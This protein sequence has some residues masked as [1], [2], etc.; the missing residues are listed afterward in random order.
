[1][2][3]SIRSGLFALGLLSS[4]VIVG[5]A[6]GEEPKTDLENT[7]LSKIPYLNR[8]FKNVS[9]DAQACEECES[10]VAPAPKFKLF[11]AEGAGVTA[12]QAGIRISAVEFPRVCTEKGCGTQACAEAKC[13]ACECPA[14]KM[15]RTLGSDGLERIG[16]DF[17]FEIEEVE[18]VRALAPRKKKQRLSR[19]ERAEAK[20][21]ELLEKLAEVLV[22]NGRLQ[23]QLEFAEERAELLAENQRLKERLKLASHAPPVLYPYQAVQATA[24]APASDT[25]L[26]RTIMHALA[27]AKESGDLKSFGIDVQIDG[28]VVTLSGVV[29]SEEQRERVLKIAQRTSGV[30]QVV[31]GLKIKPAI[32]ETYQIETLP[33]PATK[34]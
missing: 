3:L 6:C 14:G 28:G 20:E 21:R 22:E 17:D 32:V 19:A 9:Y 7:I 25:Q 16:V 2:R 11:V 12:P 33:A 18:E 13:P 1:M 34:E 26:A 31:N 24:A 27:T 4:L 23:A 10:E 15:T 5:T 8:L 29:A 30:K